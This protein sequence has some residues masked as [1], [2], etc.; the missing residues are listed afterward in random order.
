MAGKPIHKS[1]GCPSGDGP[2]SRPAGRG[3]IAGWS[4]PVARQA[5]NLKV[6]GSNPTPA[7]KSQIHRTPH[8]S[9]ASNAR[10][11]PR[12]PQRGGAARSSIGP[13]E[14]ITHTL[15]GKRAQFAS[16]GS[17]DDESFEPC[18]T[19]PHFLMGMGEAGG[20]RWVRKSPTGTFACRFAR[21]EIEAPKNTH[22]ASNHQAEPA[23]FAGFLI[24]SGTMKAPNGVRI[25]YTV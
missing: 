7:T 23:N 20:D 15:N 14:V 2:F 19:A 22:L 25:A 5:H 10:F 18:R 9:H 1:K 13:H 4:S 8:N 12:S 16:L 17:S 6:V 24:R 21:C 11:R 3:G